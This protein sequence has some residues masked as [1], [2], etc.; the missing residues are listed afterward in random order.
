MKWT[1]PVA[2]ALFATSAQADPYEHLREAS[3]ELLAASSSID[4]TS[5]DVMTKE[6]QRCNSTS[7]TIGTLAMLI[8]DT[9]DQPITYDTLSNAGIVKS[10]TSLFMQN[11][12]TVLPADQYAKTL[13]HLKASMDH[14]E[15]TRIEATQKNSATR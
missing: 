4:T 13:G 1:I 11:C 7:G 10:A 8:G 3:N 9:V 14:F 5:L 2:F 12:K 15:Q 6:G